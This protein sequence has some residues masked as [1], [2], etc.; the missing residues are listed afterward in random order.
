[1][2][3]QITKKLDLDYSNLGGGIGIFTRNVERHGDWAKVTLLCGVHHITDGLE[4]TLQMREGFNNPSAINQVKEFIRDIN[5]TVRF[6]DEPQAPVILSND[7]DLYSPSEVSGM[8][9]DFDRSHFSL[10]AETREIMEWACKKGYIIRI[11]ITQA[12]FTD[13]YVSWVKAHK[14][15]TA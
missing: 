5:P 7:D 15:A 13:K 3:K 10:T 2:T 4:I 1:M 14:A 12:H 8:M 9:R 6:S 11:S